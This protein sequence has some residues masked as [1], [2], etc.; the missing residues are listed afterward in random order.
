MPAAYVETAEF[1]CLHDDGINY[2]KKLENAGVVVE[3]NEIK[4]TMH[5]FDIVQKAP[6][7][8]A[9]VR[10]RIEYMRKMF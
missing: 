6:A 3:L 8:K 10:T 9:T 5:G 7:T 2:A 1:D 4:G